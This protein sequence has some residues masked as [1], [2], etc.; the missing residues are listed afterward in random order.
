MIMG[1]LAGLIFVASL[2]LIFSEKLNRTITAVAG[3]ALMVGLGKLFGFYSETQAIEA[4]DF[5]TWPC[6]P[7]AYRAANRCVCW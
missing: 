2:W 1:I 5:N 3:A 4:I 7:G 6:G